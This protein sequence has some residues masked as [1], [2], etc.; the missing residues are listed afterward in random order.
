M[1]AFE[2]G[3][4]PAALRWLDQSIAIRRERGRAGSLDLAGVLFNKAMVQ[5]E[6]VQDIPARLLLE[7]A[8]QLRRARLGSAHPLVGDT[9]RLL[10]EVDAALSDPQRAPRRTASPGCG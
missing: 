5:H 8:L 3:D 2:R 1:I 9:L 7:E 6:A 10:G 4:I